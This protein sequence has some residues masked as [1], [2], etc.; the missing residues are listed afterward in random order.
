MPRAGFLSKLCPGAL[1]SL[2]VGLGAREYRP[3]F[4]EVLVRECAVQTGHGGQPWV[5]SRK[6]DSVSELVQ[7]REE[8]ERRSNRA[9]SAKPSQAGSHGWPNQ[10]R[11]SGENSEKPSRARPAQF[12]MAVFANVEAQGSVM[13]EVMLKST[14]QMQHSLGNCW[15]AR[16]VS[17]SRSASTN[18]EVSVELALQVMERRAASPN[19][20]RL[21]DHQGS[22][23]PGEFIAVKPTCFGPDGTPAEQSSGLR[24][25]QRPAS[26]APAA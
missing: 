17:S 10:T 4:S 2:L 24:Q 1:V 26:P 15:E 16:T 6:C 21:R 19:R 14:D 5:H 22:Q 25:N 7:C 12:H 20:L 9:S 11:A 13:R 23:L 3:G 18:S 8:A